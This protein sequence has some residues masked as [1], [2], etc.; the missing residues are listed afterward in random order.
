[1]SVAGVELMNRSRRCFFSMACGILG[2]PTGGGSMPPVGRTGIGLE[3]AE[4]LGRQDRGGT[5]GGP[6]RADHPRGDQGLRRAEGYRHATA[7]AVCAAAGLTE[8][9]FYES[10]ANGEELLRHCFLAVEDDLLRRNRAAAGEAASSVTERALGT[11]GLSRRNTAGPGHGARVPDRD[12]Q[13]QPGSG[14]ADLGKSRP[15]WFAA[16]GRSQ[17]RPALRRSSLAASAAGRGGGRLAH[18]AEL[19]SGL[20]TAARR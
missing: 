6:A 19:G 5:S 7:K 11:P 10:F 3:H 17:C 18:R 13:C 15:V 14:C 8:R 4:D 20:T 2:A 16:D 12:G 1:M 9:Y